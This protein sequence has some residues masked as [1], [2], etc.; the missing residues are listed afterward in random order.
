MFFKD[1]SQTK[2]GVS[3]DIMMIAAALTTSLVGGGAA[4]AQESSAD[5]VVVTGSRAARAGY[6]APTPTQVIRADVIDRQGATGVAQVLMQNPAFKATRTPQANA[7]NLAS[8]AQATADL[9]G[10][11]GQRSLVLVDGSRIVPYAAASNNGSP[12]TTD[13]NLLPTLM[14]DRVEVVTGG[15]SAQYGSDAVAGVVNIFM[16]KE[17]E[18][19]RVKLQGGQADIGDAKSWKLGFVTG[20][21]FADDKAHLV[22]S[23]EWENNDGV[24]DYFKRD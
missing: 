18:G 3:R 12:N 19:L 6:V 21:N 24:H 17:Y 10:L 23:G 1:K 13:L 15:A 7:T 2:H 4:S 22:V 5:E 20:K 11:G 14:I 9:R 8:P 16:K